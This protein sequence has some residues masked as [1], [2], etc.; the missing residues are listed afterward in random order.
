MPA[1]TALITPHPK[2]IHSSAYA[3]SIPSILSSITAQQVVSSKP[4]RI[5][6]IGGG[7]SSAEVVLDLQTRLNMIPILGGGGQR[8]ELELIIGKG[9]LKPSDDSPFSNEVFDPSGECG[10][11]LF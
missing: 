8:H 10:S 9:S 5:A 3:L 2:I 1:A 4:I 7:Q 6:V 11:M